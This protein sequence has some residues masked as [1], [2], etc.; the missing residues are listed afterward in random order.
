MFY[1]DENLDPIIKEVIKRRDALLMD[2]G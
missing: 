2:N 1:T